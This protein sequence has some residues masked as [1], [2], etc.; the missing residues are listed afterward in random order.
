MNGIGFLIIAFSVFNTNNKMLQKLQ[1][2]CKTK[3]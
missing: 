1:K 3:Q 2:Q